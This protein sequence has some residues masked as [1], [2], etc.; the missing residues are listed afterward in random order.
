MSRSDKFPEIYKNLDDHFRKTFPEFGPAD[1]KFSG[2]DNE[3]LAVISYT[4]GTTGF[5]KGV[6][7]PHRSLAANIRY[8]QN[9]MPLEPGDPV[10]SFLP[11]AHTYGCAF[12]FLFPFTYGCH[13]TI[14]TKTPS[15]QILLQAFQEIRPRLILSVPL[16]IEKVYKKKMVPVISKPAMKAML[17]VPGINK[18]L[19][20][21][22]FVRSWKSASAVASRSWS[23][24]G[25][26]SMPT[27][28]SS[29][30]RSDCASP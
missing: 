6:M 18:I 28:R 1:I 30:K 20:T 24:A 23:S 21:G 14:L 25:P 9:N 16:V 12:E 27:P 5:S 11:L 3:Q 10:V 22:K 29:S 2:V 7:V 4:S 15:P 19:F 26:H 13:I 8:A 17:K